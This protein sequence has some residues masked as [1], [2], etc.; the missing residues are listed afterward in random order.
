MPAGEVRCVAEDHPCLLYAHPSLV[1]RA[2]ADLVPHGLH[3]RQPGRRRVHLHR[4]VLLF[5]PIAV[6]GVGHDF[7]WIAKPTGAIARRS[8]FSTIQVSPLILLALDVWKHTQIV[9]LAEEGKQTGKQQHV[10]GE[11]WLFVLGGTFWNVPGAGLMG[12][13]INLPAIYYYQH[14][15]FFTGAE[16]QKRCRHLARYR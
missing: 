15:T 1:P 6:I 7:R 12:S 9:E 2:V 13:M 4:E 11:G 16:F 5:F 8:V 3:P 14:A 10:M